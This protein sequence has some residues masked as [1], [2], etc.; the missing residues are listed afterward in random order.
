MLGYLAAHYDVISKNAAVKVVE[1]RLGKKEK[2]RAMNS[3][4]FS[5]GAEYPQS[6]A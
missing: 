1:E 2:F 3:K 6:E 4:A 5:L